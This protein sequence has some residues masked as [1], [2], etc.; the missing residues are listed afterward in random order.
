MHA[1]LADNEAVFP[2]SE[3]Q[4]YEL[5]PVPN[6]SG[7]ALPGGRVARSL[8]APT[9]ALVLAYSGEEGPDEDFSDAVDLLIALS[10]EAEVAFASDEQ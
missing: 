7:L 2:E 4:P 8:C 9:S 10:H 1:G 6:A 5:H 3:H